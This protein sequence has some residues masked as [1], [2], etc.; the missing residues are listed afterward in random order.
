MLV[1]R[2]V[3]EDLLATGGDHVDDFVVFKDLSCGVEIGNRPVLSW[4]R[5]GCRFGRCRRTLSW[6]TPKLSAPA[7]W[8]ILGRGRAIGWDERR[9][10]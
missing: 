5:R 7:S 4:P 2:G 6:W 1:R 8:E 3:D 10:R 9:G